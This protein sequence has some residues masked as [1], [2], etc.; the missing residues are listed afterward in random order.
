VGSRECVGVGR[1]AELPTMGGVDAHPTNPG[2]YGI[3]GVLNIQYR[4]R[5]LYT[6]NGIVREGLIH[7]IV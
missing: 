3:E 4:G 1:T 7:I 2:S 6:H 5:G